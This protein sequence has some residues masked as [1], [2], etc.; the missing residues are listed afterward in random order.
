MDQQAF[1]RAVAGV[2]RA[3]AAEEPWTVALQRVTDGAGALGAQFVCAD[4]RTGALTYSQA[5]LHAPVEAELEYVKSFHA[6][7]P[8]VPVLLQRG[9]G[10]WLYCQD[11]FTDEESASHAYYCDLLIPYGG[12]YSATMIA[13]RS[14]DETI[15][16][17]LLSRLEAGRFSPSQRDYIDRI[18][19]HLQQAIGMF[20]KVRH[21]QSRAFV[22]VG[23][24]ERISKPMFVIAP[25]RAISA[26]N[27]AAEH[28]MAEL[29]P[30]LRAVGG[31]LHV[32]DANIDQQMTLALSLLGR[33]A[34]DAAADQFIPLGGEKT[35]RWLAA[36]LANFRSSDTM[37]A[38]GADDQILVTVHARNFGKRLDPSVLQGALRLTRAEARL[39]ALIFAGRS[40]RAAASE[41]GVAETT[42]KTQLMS[43]F[44]KTGVSK[45]AELVRLISNLAA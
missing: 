15:I 13:A 35:S 20:S 41:L 3:A 2:Y 43:V 16:L 6:I 7:D 10:C 17:A 40:V 42:V 33:H 44:E 26:V 23:M 32:S 22:G 18:G 21:L 38:F 4:V 25:D 12:R 36:S 8:R 1:D 39:A 9:I 19:P 27:S 28:L 29:P 11:H 45:Q 14:D 30:P 24:I 34:A 5:N 31:R 37:L